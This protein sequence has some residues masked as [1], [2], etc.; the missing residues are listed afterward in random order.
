MKFTGVTNPRGIL[1]SQVT[2]NTQSLPACTK[3]THDAFPRITH[4]ED[5]G[6]HVEKA[7]IGLH[8]GKLERGGAVI[9]FGDVVSEVDATA[10]GVD[11]ERSGV[12]EGTEILDRVGFERGESLGV[13]NGNC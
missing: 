4:V 12:S 6:G 8:A 11:S 1:N 7:A 5:I 2:I 13:C 9:A 10:D 3:A